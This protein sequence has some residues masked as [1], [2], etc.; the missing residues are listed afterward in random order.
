MV[1][2]GHFCQGGRQTSLNLMAAQSAILLFLLMIWTTTTPGR[3]ANLDVSS[4]PGNHNTENRECLVEELLPLAVSEGESSSSEWSEERVVDPLYGCDCAYYRARY[5]CPNLGNDGY[6]AWVPH[7]VSN[8]TCDSVTLSQLLE[9]PL[10]PDFKVLVYGNSHL[11]QVVESIMCVFHER[12]STKRIKYYKNGPGNVGDKYRTVEGNVQC[13]SCSPFNDEL[14]EYGCISESEAH[15]EACTCSDNVSEFMF[16]NGA[17]LHYYYAGGDKHK[18]VSDALPHFS[19]T[20]L[21]YY[22]AV[23]ANNGNG[24]M[25]QPPQ[26]LAS[27]VELKDASVPFFWLSTYDGRN[28]R[29]GDVDGWNKKDRARMD[30]LG[31]NFIRV[32]AMALGL[33]HLRKEVVEP[34]SGDPHFCLPGPPTEMSLLLLKL[35]WAL[36]FESTRNAE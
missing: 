6:P 8:G 29:F 7:A 16:A 1:G 19:V 17:I 22:D 2:G 28:G 11:R 32:G 10:P 9:A 12:V 5:F 23:F 36:H 25:M 15:G 34:Q 26:V 21:S 35:V 33:D 3:S 31:V 4:G 24:P 20:S 18:H 13:R 14:A 30:G 27:A